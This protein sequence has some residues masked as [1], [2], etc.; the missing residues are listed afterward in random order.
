MCVWEKE[1]VGQ[2]YEQASRPGKWIERG[3]RE[4][5]RDRGGR[6]EREYVC[7]REREREKGRERERERE[8]VWQ[9]ERVGQVFTTEH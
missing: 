4:A 2:V 7:V 9:R 1:R 8:I 5:G 6:E 3:E